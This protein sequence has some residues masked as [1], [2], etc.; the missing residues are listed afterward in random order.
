MTSTSLLAPIAKPFKLKKFGNP[1]SILRKSFKV[2][3]DTQA[4]AGRSLVKGASTMT[5][6]P[7]FIQ[8]VERVQKSLSLFSMPD[9]KAAAYIRGAALRDEER[10][11]FLLFEML[12]NNPDQA[13]DRAQRVFEPYV[14]DPLLDGYS[15][16]SYIADLDRL[17]DNARSLEIDWQTVDWESR[18]HEFDDA[19][20]LRSN[21]LKADMRIMDVYHT[22]FCE[23]AET[24]SSEEIQHIQVI[25]K[26]LVKRYEFEYIPVYF[27]ASA[28]IYEAWLQGEF[29]I[30]GGKPAEPERLEKLLNALFIDNRQ[31]VARSGTERQNL[32]LSMASNFALQHLNQI[33]ESQIST[34]ETWTRSF[35]PWFACIEKSLIHKFYAFQ[36]LDN[37][38]LIHFPLII[39]NYWFA[40]FCYFYATWDGD[41][42]EQKPEI[43]AR[44]KYLKFYGTVQSVSETL[45]ISLRADT[46]QKA[47]EAISSNKVRDPEAIFAEVV[48]DYFVCFD[49]VK[50]H[51]ESGFEASPINPANVKKLYSGHGICIYGPEWIDQEDLIRNEIDGNREG[52]EYYRISGLYEE[53]VKLIE[54]DRA[55]EN[56]GRRQQ[57]YQFSHQ[58]AGLVNEIWRDK[59]RERLSDGA[60]T[61]L[62]QLKSLIEVWGDFDLEADQSIFEGSGAIFRN[63]AAQSREQLFSH[64]INTGLTHALQRSTRRRAE[65]SAATEALDQVV[66][67]RADALMFASES[68][69]EMKQQ[70]QFPDLDTGNFAST[71]FET[72]GF[73]LS[74]HHCFWQAAYHAFRAMCDEQEPP[75]LMIHKVS[76]CHIIIINRQEAIR[77]E[78]KL[79]SRDEGFYEFIQER[80]NQ[81]LQKAGTGKL[82]IRGPQASETVENAWEVSIIYTR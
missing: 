72:R 59:S 53:V 18:D 30:L 38:Y 14:Y 67:E 39:D 19:S 22:R 2:R 24:P 60:Q 47:Q 74:F 13:G 51:P 62:W 49:V 1:R 25:L 15:K 70:L 52:F 32:L 65:E 82:E 29:A 80:I 55:L 50:H 48:K 76:D 58:G 16:Q 26:K 75:Y 69:T 54:Q 79:R 7:R 46:L 64:L 9:A 35:K 40:G 42:A 23:Q 6:K 63:R 45:R 28:L 43:F 78:R 17:Y 41:D 33:E 77:E 4:S 21:A 11:K 3:I 36:N 5:S 81:S 56:E 71:W 73:I 10:P 8:Y 44:E 61:S 66:R 31:E 34:G 68:I 20:G 37:S 27:S 12:L 57:A